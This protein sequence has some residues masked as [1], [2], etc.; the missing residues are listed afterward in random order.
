MI[1]LDLPSQGAGSRDQLSTAGEFVE[2]FDNDIG[3]DDDVAIVEN[4]RRQLLQRIHLRIFIVGLARHDGGRNEFYSVDQPKL[5]RGDA[6]L[7]GKGRGG[8]ECEFHFLKSF[9]GFSPSWS[10]KSANGSAQSAAR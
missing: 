3:I 6:H 10:G 8:G 7:A 5:D 2:I 9:E 1:A 4:K